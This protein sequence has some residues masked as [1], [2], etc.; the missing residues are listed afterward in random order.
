MAVECN[1]QMILGLQI[2]GGAGAGLGARTLI[3][4]E[5]DRTG[6]VYNS[7]S[8]YP[9]TAAASDELAIT[10]GTDTIDLTAVSNPGEGAVDFTG[11]K[12]R[13]LVFQNP[14][15]NVITVSKGATNGYELNG[16]V[17]IRVPAGGTIMIDYVDALADVSGTVKTLDVVGTAAD[18][19]NYI[20]AAG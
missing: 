9:V 6:S 8:T 16:T 19:L 15:S 13:V 1:P 17:A 12:I 3:F 4:D 11:L 7:S 20:I 10:G 18:V 5:Y 14:G 2:T